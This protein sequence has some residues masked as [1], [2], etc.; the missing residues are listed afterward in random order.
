MTTTT[1][2]RVLSHADLQDAASSLAKAVESLTRRN[3]AM[4]AYLEGSNTTA[5][6]RVAAAPAVGLEDATERARKYWDKLEGRR[7]SVPPGK[8]AKNDEKE[9]GHGGKASAG[10]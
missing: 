10:E 5:A 8:S 1:K 2:R 3:A 9:K 7:S 4:R 6:E